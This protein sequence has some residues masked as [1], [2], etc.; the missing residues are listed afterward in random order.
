MDFQSCRE[1]F[2]VAVD[3]QSCR[4]IFKVAADF[5][6][7]REIFKVAVDFQSC[8][9]IFK[10][11]VDFQS[12]RE[13]FKVAVDFQSCREHSMQML[14]CNINAVPC[15]FQTVA[16]TPVGHRTFANNKF[17]SLLCAYAFRGL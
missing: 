1:I 5:Q 14:P 12:C 11:A 9:E 2:K 4:E 17:A 3:F 6:S 10:V 13:I 16:V 7:C 8:R 15:T